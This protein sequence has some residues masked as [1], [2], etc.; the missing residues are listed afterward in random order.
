MVVRRR[1]LVESLDAW[2]LQQASLVDAE[3]K[4]LLAAIVQRQA[5]ADGLARYMNMLGLERKARDATAWLREVT[6]PVP[7][8]HED[9]PTSA[10]DG[11][12][13]GSAA[14]DTR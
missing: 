13:G 12:D 6:A 8:T 5:L 10:A 4:A 11:V 2:V 3:T 14:G 1:L 7:A 9:A